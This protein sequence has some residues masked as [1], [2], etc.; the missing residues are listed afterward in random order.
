MSL[1]SPKAVLFDWDNTLVDSW[2]IIH[3]A[4][5]HT[6]GHFGHEPWSIDDIRCRVRHSM[7]DSFPALFGDEWERASNVFTERFGAIHVERLAVLPGAA[8]LIDELTDRGLTLAVVS[9]KRGHFLRKE[10][11]HLGWDRYFHALIG[12]NDA[13]RDKPAIEPVVA[14]L[15]GSGI[16]P[17]PSVWFAGDADIDMRCA[18]AAGATAVLIRDQA[19]GDGEFTDCRPHAHVAD[20]RTFMD[21]V[22]ASTS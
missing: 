2:A 16:A 11:T 6:L 4:M 10:I 7:R 18:H 22:R 20:C 17:G 19:P 14:A 12:A 3:D 15:D 1:P 5:N 21:L 13:A 8:E 9:N